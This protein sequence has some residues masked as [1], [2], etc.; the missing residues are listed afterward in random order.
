MSS[1][2]L[3]VEAS[4]FT[5]CIPGVVGA[6]RLNRVVDGGMEESLSVLLMFDEEYLP[7][8]VKMGYFRYEVRAFVSKPLFCRNCKRYGHVSSVCRRNVESE[9]VRCCYCNGNH[10]PNSPE[11]P[12]RVKVCEVGQVYTA[13]LLHGG[14]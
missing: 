9:G 6:W 13:G 7:S 14:T 10:I 5:R 11:C 2:V 3:N 8:H 12:V 4:W 1:L